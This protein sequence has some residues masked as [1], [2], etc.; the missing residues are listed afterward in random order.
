MGSHGDLWPIPL[1][2]TL[3]ALYCSASSCARPA[4]GPRPTI[5]PM[6]AFG[7]LNR[8]GREILAGSQNFLLSARFLFTLVEFRIGRFRLKSHCLRFGFWQTIQEISKCTNIQAVPPRQGSNR[9]D[10][11]A[12][13]QLCRSLFLELQF[14]GSS[15]SQFG[16]F[17]TRVCGMEW[18]RTEPAVHE[19]RAKKNELEPTSFC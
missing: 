13:A 4:R 14:S 8:D 1:L 6:H 19:P 3:S 12:S 18:A 17:A 11:I 15:G 5:P 9:Q 2:A 16:W 10:L 7:P